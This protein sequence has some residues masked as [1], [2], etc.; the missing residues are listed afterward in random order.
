M[1]KF[2]AALLAVAALTLQCVQKNYPPGLYAR[3]VTTKGTIVAALEYEKA[4]MTVANFVGLS[5]GK[6]HSILGDNVRFYDGLKFHRVEPDF[7]IQGGDPRGDGSGGPGYVFPD[8]ISPDLKH[9]GPGILSM[10]NAGPGANGSQFFI[11]L[12]AAPHLDGRCPV[13]GH[14]IEGMDAVRKIAV[15]DRILSVTIIRSGAGANAFRADQAAF[16]SL[17]KQAVDGEQRKRMQEAEQL[18]SALSPRFPKAV[19]MSCG[20][21]YEVQRPGTGR[22]PVKGDHVKVQYTGTLLESGAKFDS[23]RDRNKP[24]EFD[25]GLGQ[26]IPGWDQAVLDMRIGERRTVV[27][28]ASLAYGENGVPGVIPPNATLVFDVELLDINAGK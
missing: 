11:T 3:I 27:I 5:E 1:K 22:K 2:A 28:P 20:I 9:D 21:L 23:S 15:G 6:I 14:V 16:D 18:K 4:P 7:A 26:V 13:F 8:E 24:F 10:A 17:V 25:V 12:A 19:A